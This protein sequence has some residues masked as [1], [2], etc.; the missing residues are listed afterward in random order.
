[1]VASAW[2]AVD[3]DCAAL[4]HVVEVVHDAIAHHRPPASAS[5]AVKCRSAGFEDGAEEAL[6]RLEV[7]CG[8]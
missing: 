8:P 5:D 3:R 2:A 1:M 7:Q 4:P 6:S